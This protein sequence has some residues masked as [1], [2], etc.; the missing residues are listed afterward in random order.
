MNKAILV[1]GILGAFLVPACT[2]SVSGTIGGNGGSCD[3]VSCSDALAA[4]VVSGGI[5]DPAAATAYGDLQACG[6]S[7]GYCSAECG[8]NFCA[9]LGETATCGDCLDAQCGPEHATCAS[10]SY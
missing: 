9:D 8:D 1:M 4:G 3:A 5:C 10:N 7:T 6:C 2:A